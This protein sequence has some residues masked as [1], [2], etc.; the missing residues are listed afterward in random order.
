MYN[1][2]WCCLWR[3]WDRTGHETLPCP[4]GVAHATMG[5]GDVIVH[6]VVA[7]LLVQH[8]RSTG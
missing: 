8:R 4:A 1:Q 3:W 5:A 6:S 2:G 7:I